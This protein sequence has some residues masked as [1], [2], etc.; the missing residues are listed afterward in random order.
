MISCSVPL[1]KLP[2]GSSIKAVLK[3]EESKNVNDLDPLLF[4]TEADKI[5][6]MIKAHEPNDRAYLRERLETVTTSTL[7]PLRRGSM[8]G[9]RVDEEHHDN[10]ASSTGLAHLDLEKAARRQ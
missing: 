8:D 1:D 3:D 6:D 10:L 2:S 5:H 9:Y 7:H 4:P